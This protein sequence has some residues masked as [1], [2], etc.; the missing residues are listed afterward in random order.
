MYNFVQ[1]AD[2]LG[3]QVYAE[4]HLKKHNYMCQS[5]RAILKMWQVIMFHA[6]WQFVQNTQ[7]RYA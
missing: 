7:I 6:F 3:Y 2:L 4:M 5:N 1:W